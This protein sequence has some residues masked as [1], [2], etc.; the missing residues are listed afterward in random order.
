[1]A[2]FLCLFSTQSAFGQDD[3]AVPSPDSAAE[4]AVSL[5]KVLIADLAP[6]FR[7]VL[8]GE[9][10]ST[11]SVSKDENGGVFVRAEPIFEALNNEYEFN[12]D[13][14]VLIVQRSQDGVVMELYTD[15]GIVKANGRALGKLTAFG[16]VREGMINLTPNAI[17]VLSGAIGKIDENENVINFEL[18]PRLK[19]ATGFEVFVND[20]PLGQIEPAPKSIGS[21]LLLP[22][23]PIAKELGHDVQI[24]DGGTSVRVR[25]SQDSAIFELNLDTGLVKLNGRPHGVTKDVTYI[26]D[27]NLL[28]PISAIETLT[29][30]HINV[31]GGTSQINVV[32]DDRLSGA[33]EPGERV[34][35]I[36]KNEPFVLETL[37]FHVG[38]DTQNKAE[39]EFRAKGTNGRI[40]Y[41]I[42]DL[43]M[44]M[45]EAEPAWL[46]LDFAHSSGAKGSLGDYS[47]DFREL[48]GVGLR[49]IRGAAVSKVTSKGRWAMAAGAPVTGSR[50][51]SDDQSRTE[52]GG[53]A[54]G[55][56][57]ADK[58]GWEAGL[59][60]KKE[61]LS[62]DQMVVLSAISGRLGRKHD[63]KVN[64]DVR[65]DIGVFNGEA[66]VKSVDARA[67]ADV[68][69]EVNDN[70]NVD[71][72]ASYDG[73]EFLRSDLD[74]EDLQTTINPDDGTTA[75]DSGTQIV[76]DLRVRG[77]DLLRVG[78]AVQIAARKSI[79]PLNRP[80]ASVRY[81]RKQNGI[82]TEA[83]N[84]TTVDNYGVS[85]STAITP[86]DTNI[87][88]DW[89]G[90]DQKQES[91]T[92]ETGDQISA[93][94]YKDTKYARGRAQFTSTK[95]QDAPRV[96]RFDAQISATPYRLSLPK[97]GSFK[98]APSIAASWNE[99]NSYVRAGVV[100][101]L[102]SG[103]LL[104]KKTQL[105]ASLGVLQNFS[106]NA[107]DRSDTFLTVGIGRQLPIN[108]NLRMGM[109][110]RNDLRG[111]QRVGIYLDG[112]FGFNEKRKFRNTQEGRGVLKGRAFFDKNRDGI[113]QEDEPGIG[114]ALVRIKGTR[115]TLRTDHDGYYTVQ[116]IK[117][118]LHAIQL[119][120]RSLPLGFTLA[121]NAIT[122]ATIRE[123][124]ITDVPLPIVQ[125]GQI[126]GF[127]FV[128]TD[129]NGE[130]NSGEVRL[131]G[132]KLTLVS[133]DDPAIEKEIYA[134]SFG[135]FAFDDLPAGQYEI[136]ILKTNNPGS[137]PSDAVIVDLG[138]DD[139]L[140]VKINIA[141][142]SATMT[143][144][145]QR[146]P[147]TGNPSSVMKGRDVEIPPP[148]NPAP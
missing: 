7:V 71:V 89:S 5:N 74:A 67:G 3:Q 131:E 34:D 77:D 53:L 121:D 50:Q 86:I 20:I 130:H 136:S 129:K 72:F 80:A 49:R 21:V 59:S 75:I 109:S 32:L 94:I 138:K 16:E 85:I 76:P 78:A 92:S 132:A 93:R 134:A 1:V 23:R 30:T 116:N 79:G 41:E 83:D 84:K 63:K 148:D 24:I 95:K 37:S 114:G 145:A 104:G 73:E 101:N 81:S 98:I 110:Y 46:S 90:Y 96:E 87:T 105:N 113:K 58:D 135:Q 6:E 35:D 111:E 27:I 133:L 8:E 142:V 108:K 65:A 18:D 22:L 10:L 146:D 54:A 13:E 26:E 12:I 141:A 137:E 38:T 124:H 40:R 125:R 112:N 139:D 68:R 127:V 106:G 31:D 48:D 19:V 118:G 57:Y 29:G 119:D 122:R 36:T 99:M 128:D 42:P 28:L 123:G 117:K 100:A 15:T 66:R 82:L 9:E 144:M 14:G 120:G 2:A 70:I 39:V 33:I 64:W 91:G 143:E 44:G 45:A 43:P 115:L 25:R 69:Y 55:V 52:F 140:M 97:E 11:S 56:R 62:D 47:A 4:P 102:D 61:G 107:E 103:E 88:L 147:A 51:I 17:A 126:R 60:Y